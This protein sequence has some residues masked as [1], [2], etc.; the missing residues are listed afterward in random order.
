[1]DLFA[2][3]RLPGNI[4]R[5]QLGMADV[6]KNEAEAMKAHIVQHHPDAEVRVYPD[7]LDVVLPT[8]DVPKEAISLGLSSCLKTERIRGGAGRA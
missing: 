7:M 5:H 8:L 6:G 4:A 2:P 3:A 1:M